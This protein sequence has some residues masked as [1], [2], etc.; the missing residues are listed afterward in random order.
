MSELINTTLQH[1][2]CVGSVERSVEDGC[3]FGRL[4]HIS[5]LVSYEGKTFAELHV[6]FRAAVDDYLNSPEAHPF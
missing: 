3:L 1:R 5:A 2:G 6:A 4:Q